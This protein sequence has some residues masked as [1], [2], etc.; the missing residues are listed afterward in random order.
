META[1]IF[2]ALAGILKTAKKYH[3][4][5]FAAEQLWQGQHDDT[6]IR[7]L[8]EEHDGIKIKRRRKRDLKNAPGNAKTSGFGHSFE[9]GAKCEV[10]TK[11]IYQAEWV[12]AGGKS[13][14]KGCFV[15]ASC[16]KKLL[17]NNYHVS[18]D[19]KYRCQRCH[20]HAEKSGT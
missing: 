13:Y 5:D 7:L 6:I 20:M 2:D 17:M 12:G 19:R 18:F 16:G 4:V 11:T 9:Q 10:C 14:H 1:D 3:V 8:K 15:C